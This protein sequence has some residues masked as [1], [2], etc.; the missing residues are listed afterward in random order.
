MEIYLGM[1]SDY[2]F[3]DGLLKEI[4]RNYTEKSLHLLIECKNISYRKMP[5]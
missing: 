4:K 2:I 3:Y 5:L 1:F